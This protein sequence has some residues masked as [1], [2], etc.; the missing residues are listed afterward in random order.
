MHHVLFLFFLVM[1]ALLFALIEIQIEGPHGWATALPTWRFE[2]RWSRALL[3]NRNITGYHVFSHLFI[4]AVLH[5][6]YALG[7]TPFTLALECRI[8]AFAFLFWVVEDFLWF[9][10]NP[11]YGARG[12]RPERAWWHAPNWWW[13]MP[14]DYWLFLPIGIALYSLS[15]T[16]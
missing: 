15:Y 16:V 12:F 2:S 4:L 1:T 10:C 3:G 7:A 11:A 6:P 5:V 13:I 8:L 9:L 14:R